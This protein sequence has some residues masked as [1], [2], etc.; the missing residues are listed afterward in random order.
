[1]AWKNGEG[2][3]QNLMPYLTS[4]EREKLMTGYCEECWQDLFK[5]EEEW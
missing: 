2:L 5:N 1:M 3:I 4:D